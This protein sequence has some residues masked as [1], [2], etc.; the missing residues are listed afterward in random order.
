[1]S[2]D[3]GDPLD[4]ARENLVT[5]LV[6]FLVVRLLHSKEKREAAGIQILSIAPAAPIA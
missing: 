4:A 1:M 6:A 2:T 5:I 3:L